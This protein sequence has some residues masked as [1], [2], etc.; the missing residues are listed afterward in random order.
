MR[1]MTIKEAIDIEVQVYG[2]LREAAK[3]LGIDAGYLSRLAN[4]E[5]EN[6]GDYVLEQLRLQKKVV[7]VR[8]TVNYEPTPLIARSKSA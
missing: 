2:S 8:P 1:E 3:H 4:G 6:P 5:K 7:Y